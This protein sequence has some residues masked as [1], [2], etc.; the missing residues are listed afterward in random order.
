MQKSKYM[1]T[2]KDSDKILLSKMYSLT[3][4][5]NITKLQYWNFKGSGLLSIKQT[6]P[7]KLEKLVLSCK[8]L[9]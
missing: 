9:R 3:K 2:L 6:V 1:Q 5:R 8:I 4:K 7:T